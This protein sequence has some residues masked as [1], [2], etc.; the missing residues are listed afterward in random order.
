M[1]T[2]RRFLNPRTINN[3]KNIRNYVAPSTNFYYT[4]TGEWIKK[5][6][7][8]SYIGLTHDSL[9]QLSEIVFMESLVDL[10]DLVDKDTELIAIESVKATATI[11]AQED[12]LILEFNQDL[13]EDLDLL[14]KNPEDVDKCWIVKTSP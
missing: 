1:L 12:C 11:N 5:V 8:T 3:L 2:A 7:N 13:F 6:E 14:N 9:E 10:E 4:E